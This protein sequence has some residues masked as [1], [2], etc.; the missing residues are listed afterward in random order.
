RAMSLSVAPDR[1]GPLTAP[2]GGSERSER[3]GTFH[4]CGQQRAQR[5]S[6]NFREEALE[7]GGSRHH[8]DAVER[9]AKR[10]RLRELA[11][12]PAADTS[13]IDRRH[14]RDAQRIGRRLQRQRRTARK[15]DARAIAGAYVLVDAVAHANV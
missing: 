11:A 7:C 3:G 10:G 5:D 2:P 8:F 12:K 4:L 1:P 9:R 14:L 13:G 15:T 6:A